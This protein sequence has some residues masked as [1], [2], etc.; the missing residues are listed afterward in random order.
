M[1]LKETKQLLTMLWSMYPNAPKLSRDDKEVM[2][3][4]WVGLM[5][6]FALED[7]WKAVK[8]CFEREPRYIPTAPEVL[9]KCTKDYKTERFLPK[10]Y[11]ELEETIDRSW[12]ATLNRENIYKQLSQKDVES[13]DE[14]QKSIYNKVVKERETDRRLDEMWNEAYN[15]A[16]VAYEQTERAKLTEDGATQRLKQLAII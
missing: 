16:R 1:N 15:T 4:A 14:E 12:A 13:M 5:Y 8:Q 11:E 6:E 2:A 10:E 7:V 9:S 3:M